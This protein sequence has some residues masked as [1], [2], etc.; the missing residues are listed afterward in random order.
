VA[1]ADDADEDDHFQFL[2]K[3]YLEAKPP[4]LTTS[5][6]LIKHCKETSKDKHIFIE[7][8][9]PDCRF[10]AKFMNDFNRIYDYF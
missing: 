3:W 8:F 1:N 2:S 5:E 7:F 9:T 10:C 6:E 4:E